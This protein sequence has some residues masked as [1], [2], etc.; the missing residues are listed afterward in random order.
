MR[1]AIVNL[2]P[3]IALERKLNTMDFREK[4]EE[5]NKE[6]L[7]DIIM[8]ISDNG[9]YPM[10]LILLHGPSEVDACELEEYWKS[11][12]EAAKNQEDINSDQAAD[13]IRTGAEL[14]IKKAKMLSNEADMQS[15][16]QMMVEDLHEAAE[17]DGIGMESDS[18]W[19][20]LDYADKL[21]RE[22]C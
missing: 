1:K 15:F 14:C 21:E 17:A 3:I 20:Y 11:I 6:D 19:L 5:F 18:E 10:P 22:Y 9:Y 4:L 12:Y 16:C 13:I 2:T 8:E 7:I